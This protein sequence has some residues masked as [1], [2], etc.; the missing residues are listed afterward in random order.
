M[1]A[2]AVARCRDVLRKV[3]SADRALLA[4]IE[5]AFGVSIKARLA[6]DAVWS[7]LVR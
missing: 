5:P 3:W 7:E 1:T 2:P 6:D 4:P